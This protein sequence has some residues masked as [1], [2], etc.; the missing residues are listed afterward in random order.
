V[1]GIYPLNEFIDM[2]LGGGNVSALSIVFKRDSKL[3]K[4]SGLKFYSDPFG[5]NEIYK[6]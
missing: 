2:G 1:E 3:C 5:I 4:F 6:I